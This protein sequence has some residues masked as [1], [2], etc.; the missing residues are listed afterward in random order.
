MVEYGYIENGYLRSRILEPTTENYQEKDN[1]G[2]YYIKTRV[3]TIQ[4]QIENLDPIWKP[5]APIDEDK[6]VCED[7]YIVRLIPY[8]AGDHIDYEYKKVL[9]V[10]KYRREISEQ[11]EYLNGTDYQVAKCNEAYMLGDPLP[12]DLEAL[13][14]ARQAARDKINELEI[15]LNQAQ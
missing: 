2:F 6:R 7:G 12:Y 9:D 13:H 10:Q 4:E 5:V 14:T 8:D 3:V 1:D 11:K 15:I